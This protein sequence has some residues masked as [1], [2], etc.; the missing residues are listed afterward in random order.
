MPV[1]PRVPSQLL[2]WLLAGALLLSVGANV[3]LLTPRDRAE[4]TEVVDAQLRTFRDDDNAEED[5]ASWAS[6][7]EELRQTRQQLADCQSQHSPAAAAS[8]GP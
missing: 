8:P 2:T 7:T 1:T 6:L 5:D 3:Y 4:R